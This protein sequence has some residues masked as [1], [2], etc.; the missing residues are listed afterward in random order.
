[1]REWPSNQLGKE[2]AKSEER[3]EK[4]E[5]YHEP[6]RIMGNALN[7][8]LDAVQKREIGGLYPF[9]MRDL[10]QNRAE[11]SNHMVKTMEQ[12]TAG[13]QVAPLLLLE[14]AAIRAREAVLQIEHREKNMY[15][16]DEGEVPAEEP[17]EHLFESSKR[18]EFLKLIDE[19]RGRAGIVERV[20]TKGDFMEWLREVRK[21]LIRR[22]EAM[23]LD[24]GSKEALEDRIEAI[25]Q[26]LK[27]ESGGAELI[28]MV[29]REDIS[30]IAVEAE[31][32]LLSVLDKPQRRILQDRLPILLEELLKREQF[33]IFVNEEE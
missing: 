23:K 12:G 28:E 25:G 16:D 26:F 32:R 29:L 21:K 19:V 22:V 17:I 15:G 5:L 9:T 14:L 11:V 30:G 3:T 31:K 4:E 10:L 27:K 1:M 33:F 18:E 6:E 13:E 2:S 8:F 24:A 7:S 20:Y